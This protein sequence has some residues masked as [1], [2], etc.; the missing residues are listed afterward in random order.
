MF[1][2]NDLNHT[3]KIGICDSVQEFSLI[4]DEVSHAKNVALRQEQTKKSWQDQTA[5]ARKN[6]RKWYDKS[7]IPSD[8]NVPKSG[9][10]MRE[11]NF[12]YG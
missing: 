9:E 5:R 12:L 3:C 11:D 7:Q 2:Q 8:Q 6:P 10:K 1:K 4:S